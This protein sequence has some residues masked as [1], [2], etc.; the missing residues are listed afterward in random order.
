MRV[1]IA[2]DDAVSRTI[3]RKTVERFGHECL[4]AG[5]G[6]EAWDLFQ[7]TPGVEVIVSDWMMP[8]VDGL[9][10]CRRVRSLDPPRCNTFF[11]F[12]TALGGKEHLMEGMRAG[13][14]EYLTKPLDSEQLRAKLLAASRIMS[15]HQHLD[16]EGSSE[17]ALRDGDG[18][19]RTYG[20]RT[21]GLL[22]RS[23]P[24]IGGGKAWDILV[25]QDKISEQQL[26]QALEAQKSDRRD[27]GRVLVSLGFITEMDLAQAQAQRLNLDYIELTEADVDRD[28]LGLV[29]EKVL[30]KHRA[31]PLHTKDRQLFVAMSDPTNIF[32]LEDLGM[33]SGYKVVPVVTTEEDLQRI[34]T[35]VFAMGVQVTGILEDAAEADVEDHGDVELGVEAG[36]NEAPVVLLVNSI[37]QRAV[38][39]GASDI[40]V[41][42]QTQGLTI[43]LRVDGVLREVMSVPSKLQ[44]EVLARLKILANLD[45]AEK[46]LPQDG[47]FSVKLGGK[48]MDLR[49]ASLP[50]VFG[51]EMVL[52]L[53]DTSSLD[54]DLTQL[55]FAPEILK[56]YEEVFRRPYGTILV[57]GPTGSGKS[58]TLYATLG[59]LNSQEKKIITVEDPVELRMQG[60]NQIQ[61]N[62]KIGLTFASGLRSILRSDPDIVMIGEIRDLETAKISI[63]AA[64]TGHLVLSTLHTNNAPSAVNRLTDMGVEPFLT[65]S[66]VDCVIAQR[67]AR[68]LC[69]FCKQPA[70]MEEGVLSDMQFPFE[71]APDSGLRFYRAVGCERCGG[72]GYR[73]RLGIYELMVITKEIRE[74]IMLRASTD[75]ISRAAK[76]Q[77]MVRLRDDGLLKAA[78]G[79]TTVEEVLRTV[80]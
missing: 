17:V 47:R 78:Q 55:G 66:A 74:L 61:A 35:R 58:T 80:V 27:L 22:S 57:T 67:L 7:N 76:D 23:K 62:P 53:L 42:P 32:A 59:E 70:G 44:N 40:H 36:A 54:V 38:G 39:E 18:A 3:L 13:A 43:R 9:E 52:R 28:A 16:R 71:H 21:T 64:L 10:F 77:G 65:S 26:Q 63:E 25:S 68:R 48:K 73:A 14:D 2:E 4:V 20:N 11:V 15:T 49:V 19:T 34:Q 31:L 56:K 50:T 5:D 79:I 30:R 37:L 33:I 6:A 75:E 46:R 60:V 24:R 12:L 1:L 29:P 41:E 72:S 69:S 45:I 51:E 8:N